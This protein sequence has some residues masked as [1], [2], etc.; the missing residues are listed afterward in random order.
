[1]TGLFAIGGAGHLFEAQ[2][3]NLHTHL[4]IRGGAHDGEA[5]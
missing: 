4:T 5:S 1:M 2:L 3:C